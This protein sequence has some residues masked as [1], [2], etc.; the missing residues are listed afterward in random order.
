MGLMLKR[1]LR[2]LVFIP[3]NLVVMLM[4]IFI[5]PIIYIISGKIMYDE[6]PHYYVALIYEKLK[7]TNRV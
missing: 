5:F 6:G 3:A 7:L 2:V 4:A 1:L